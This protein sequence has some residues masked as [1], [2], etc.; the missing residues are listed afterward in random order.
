MI[1]D[2]ER[3]KADNALLPQRQRIKIPEKE[4]D[5]V[6]LRWQGAAIGALQEASEAYLIG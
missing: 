3:Q 4:E 2:W 5:L 1:V 6:P